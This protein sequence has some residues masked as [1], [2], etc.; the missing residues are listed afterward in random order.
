MGLVR[1]VRCGVSYMRS[2]LLPRREERSLEDFIIQP[3]RPAALPDVF[4]VVYGKGLGRALPRDQ[5]RMG[6]A[7]H[8]GALAQGSGG[9]LPQKIIQPEEVWRHRSEEY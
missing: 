7:A 1:T 2:A 6:S 9:A 3:L 5:R 8:Q 4:Q